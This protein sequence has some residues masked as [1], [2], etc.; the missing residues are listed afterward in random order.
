MT[1]PKV[2]ISAEVLKWARVTRFSGDIEEAA[3]QLKVK[4]DE[5]LLWESEGIE[6]SASTIR[7]VSRVYK[8]PITVFLLKTAPKSQLPPKFRRFS[9]EDC[10]LSID[11][12]MIIRKAQEIQTSALD[13]LGNKENVF[14]KKLTTDKV[15]SELMAKK[16]IDLLN[17]SKILRFSS[18][19]TKEQLQKWKRLLESNNIMVLEYSFPLFDSRAFTIFNKSIPVIVLNSRDSDNGRVFSL[20]HEFGHL[21]LRQ[22]EFD[23]EITLDYSQSIADELYCNQIS[24]NI[25]VPSEELRKRVKYGQNINESI[26]KDIANEFKVSMSV[27]W[28][29]LYDNKLIDSTQYRKIRSKLS[30]FE[31]FVTEGKKKKFGANKNTHLYKKI[32]NMGELYIG[33]TLEAFNENRIS[34][35]EVLDYLGIKSNA[36]PRLQ[37]IMFT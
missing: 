22:S 33:A 15:N 20:F 35:Y 36:L 12:L 21:L 2:S 6:M 23:V 3:R 32:K 9:F 11:T 1:S 10:I 28:R 7:K 8:R 17:I 25:L 30:T 18:K 31:P 34:H 24:A 4:K 14:I 26:V 19:N 27:I 29:R 16:A 13:L 5:I 37:N